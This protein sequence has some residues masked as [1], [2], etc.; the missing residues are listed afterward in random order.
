MKVIRMHVYT[1]THIHMYVKKN[2]ENT[3]AYV[4]LNCI[5]VHI[6]YVHFF[7]NA[8]F[9]FGIFCPFCLWLL[10]SLQRPPQFCCD[11]CGTPWWR[12]PGTQSSTTRSGALRGPAARWVALTRPPQQKTPQQVGLCGWPP[13][14]D[15]HSPHGVSGSWWLPASNFQFFL[16]LSKVVCVVCSQAGVQ[17]AFRGQSLRPE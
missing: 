6:M 4:S 9:G 2:A 1:D 11:N 8:R 7:N 14:P 10:G 3:P 5:C 12:R 17:Q 15:T 16:R 13:S